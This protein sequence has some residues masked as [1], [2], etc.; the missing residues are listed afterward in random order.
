M[1]V[2]LLDRVKY[3]RQ[4]FCAEDAGDWVP[5]LLL[6]WNALGALAREHP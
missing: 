6:A 3:S 5:K 1:N 4:F 2:H